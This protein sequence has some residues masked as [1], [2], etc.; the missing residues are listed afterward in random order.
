[1]RILLINPPTN[2]E[3]LYSEWDLSDVKSYSPPIGLLSIM[4][5]LKLQGHTVAFMDQ[6]C[7]EDIAINMGYYHP[8]VV[9]ITAMT[10]M[11]ESAA[12]VARIVKLS[13]HPSIT[14]IGG[15]HITALPEETMKHYGVFDYGIVGEGEVAFADFLKRDNN[16][17]C[18]NLVHRKDGKV[19]VNP[20]REPIRN[21]DDLPFADYGAIV[22]GKN[23][24]SIFGSKT[25]R[26]LGI[27][28]SRG[29][30]GQCTFCDRG[31]FGRK[32]RCHSAGY[33]LKLMDSLRANHEVTDF[34]F[35][36]D[37][38][39]ANRDRLIEFCD[40]IIK[41]KLPYTWSCCAR[42]DYVDQ[43][44]LGLM[45]RA[46][47][48]LIEY[49]IESGNQEILNK[50]NKKITLERIYETVSATR[51]EGIEAK[52]NFI[53]GNIGEAESTLRD[54]IEFACR[55]PL[56]YFQHTFLA[57][58][59]G[60][61]VWDSASD[62]GEF[63]KEWKNCNT[64]AISFV[65]TGLTRERLM[66][67]SKMAWRKFYLRPHIIWRE[68]FKGNLWIKMKTFLKTVLR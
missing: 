52:G 29:C 6:P 1:M 51:K 48:W 34:L 27:V 53:F 2:K 63:R 12:D 22:R 64:F 31:V 38:F 56:S 17:T 11:I 41:K 19:Y 16:C 5:F 8:D 25:K 44:L 68:L 55:L 10:L 60:S 3:Q 4:S 46:G 28:S 40:T 15:P 47:C 58:L 49:G 13:Q 9:A 23:R 30:P 32:F 21:L 67:Y 20:R 42:A 37:L 18:K 57:P 59:P 33:V 65:P 24:L 14:V 62:A 7:A 45:K 39:V 50:M 54:T 35:Y 61:E 36:D 43:K 66:Y 26:S